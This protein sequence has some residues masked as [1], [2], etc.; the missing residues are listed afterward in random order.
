MKDKLLSTIGIII[1]AL[2]LIVF[3]KWNPYYLWRLK[4]MVRGWW[5]LLIIIPSV[6]SIL[7]HE[8]NIF[9]VGACLIGIVLFLS[10]RYI[11]TFYWIRKYV[12]PAALVLLGAVII[13]GVK[14]K[15]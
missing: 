13:F 6:I 14:T 15:K 1:I 5:T 2:G 12:V 8:P 10:S 11:I 4:F 9:N 3:I 7:K